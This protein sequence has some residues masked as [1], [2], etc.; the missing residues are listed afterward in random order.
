MESTAFGI[1]AWIGLCVGV[2]NRI[3]KGRK[4]FDIEKKPFLALGWL[5]VMI[6]TAIFAIG[7]LAKAMV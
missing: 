6:I 3:E 5:S 1:A 2:L 7:A 4:Y